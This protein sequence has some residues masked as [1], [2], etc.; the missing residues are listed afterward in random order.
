MIEFSVNTATAVIVYL[1]LDQCAVSL[2]Q[3]RAAYNLC[4][5]SPKVASFGHCIGIHF[6]PSTELGGNGTQM[7]QTRKSMGV[8]K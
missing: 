3:T 7:N 4:F 1:S 8:S 5:F 2:I 6:M